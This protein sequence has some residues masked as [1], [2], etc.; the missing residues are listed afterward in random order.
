MENHLLFHLRILIKFQELSPN[1]DIVHPWKSSDAFLLFRVQEAIS[2]SGA[3]V[4]IVNKITPLHAM[5]SN[6]GS[7]NCP[8]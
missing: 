8:G 5:V 7:E 4:E 1:N 6:F 3:V 2:K